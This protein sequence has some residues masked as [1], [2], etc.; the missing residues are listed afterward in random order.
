MRSH[1]MV[2][3][4]DSQCGDI[5]GASLVTTAQHARCAPNSHTICASAE[6]CATIAAKTRNDVRGVVCDKRVVR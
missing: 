3:G 4:M 2:T 5:A 6:L 1:R